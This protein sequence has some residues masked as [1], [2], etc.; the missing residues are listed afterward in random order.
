MLN[1]MKFK[2]NFNDF[3][4]ELVEIANRKAM[5]TPCRVSRYTI[6]KDLYK[7]ELREQEFDFPDDFDDENPDGEDTFDYCVYWGEIAPK[8]IVN[9]EGTLLFNERL[10]PERIELDEETSINFLGEEISYEEFK[11]II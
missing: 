4:Y 2:N 6:P 1:P 5:F 3:N 9:F 8:I 11:K 10:N 7:Y